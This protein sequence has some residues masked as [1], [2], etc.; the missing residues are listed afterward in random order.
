LTGKVVVA[1]AEPCG[2]AGFA[3]SFTVKLTAYGLPVEAKATGLAEH[4]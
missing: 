3:V 2:T 4:V 1:V